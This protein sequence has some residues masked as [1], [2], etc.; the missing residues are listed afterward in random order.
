MAITK[1]KLSNSTNGKQILVTQTT[2]GSADQIHTAVAGTSTW[3]EIYIYATNTNSA[4]VTCSLMWG[5]QAEPND[6]VSFILNP[7]SG[8]TLIADGKL[9]QN[10]LIVRAYASWANVV[11]IDGFVN[12]IS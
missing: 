11:V 12:S 8:R 2:S 3:D 10:G 5:G 1:N 6:R 9:L 7:T 4:S